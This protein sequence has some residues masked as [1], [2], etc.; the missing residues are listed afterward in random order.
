MNENITPINEK[1]QAH[2]YWEVY[3]ND[4][5]LFCKCFYVNGRMN[6]YIEIHV[7]RHTKIIDIRFNL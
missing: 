3:R 7:L 6:G 4:G 1:Y 2:G 5:K